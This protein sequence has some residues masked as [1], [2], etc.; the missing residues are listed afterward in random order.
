MCG[1]ASWKGLLPRR[2]LEGTWRLKGRSERPV[3]LLRG[4]GTQGRPDPP[5]PVWVLLNSLLCHRRWH[6]CGWGHAPWAS[7]GEGPGFS[8]KQPGLAGSAGP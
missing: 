6:P 5:W 8:G 1:W 7:S 2:G 4:E 3:A